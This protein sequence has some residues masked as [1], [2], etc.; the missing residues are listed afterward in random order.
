MSIEE[1]YEEVRELLVVGREQGYLLRDQ[2][3]EALPA[4]LGADEPKELM[5]ALA[6]G[7]IEVIDS[8]GAGASG[9]AAGP[10][11]ARL[12]AGAAELEPGHHVHDEAATAP[13][14]VRMYLRQIGTVRLLTRRGEVKIAQRM[15][16]AERRVMMSLSRSLTI[17]KHLVQVSQQLRSGERSVRELVTVPDG[18][19][20]EL[21]GARLAARTRQVV[22]R[23]DDIGAARLRLR[24]RLKRLAA[25]PKRTRRASRRAE[26]KTLRAWIALSRAVRTLAFTEAMTRELIHIVET[27]DDEVRR[28]QDRVARIE[29]QLSPAPTRAPARG[30][31][32]V[33]AG[34]HS[35]QAKRA[36]HQLVGELEETPE[37]LR[38]TRA[39]IVLGQARGAQAKRDLI[40]ANLR[41]VVSIAKK[42][43]NRGLA[44]LD[45]I[46]EGNIGLMRA[47]DKFDY[48]RGY[49]F[50]T[51]A[52]WWIRQAITRAIADHG[53]TIRIPV[54]MIDTINRVMRASQ[55]LVQ[56]LGREP[57][58]REIA[59]RTGVSIAKVQKVTKIA[60]QPIS[61][62]SPIGDDEDSR[63]GD[64]IEDRQANSPADA[65]FDLDLQQQTE[66]V[67]KTLTPRE[68]EVVR[69]RFGLRDG[70]E[71]TLAEVGESFALT[72]ER[73]RQIEAIALRKLRESSR[74]R[75]LRSFL[76][77]TPP[78]QASRRGETHP[79]GQRRSG[80]RSG[81]A[82]RARGSVQVSAEEQTT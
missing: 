56:E 21:T 61:L 58:V 5:A 36:L 34:A 7:G 22:K 47:V 39:A 52:T 29:G 71:P 54:H 67:L 75:K 80:P 14:P 6:S 65:V 15:E 12:S 73:I 18:D 82:V 41:L 30:A 37:R 74:N 45:L 2:I 64:F 44:F 81:R 27:A 77:W 70:S 72:R 62:E 3:S 76:E 68:Q 24:T 40:E 43:S 48:H 23:I 19:D 57:T 16:R 79:A 50:S 66:S 59:E 25:I 4:D 8:E 26:W 78:G 42:Y 60:Q 69:R 31:V 17:A 51:Y 32:H 46:Q 20:A 49:K 55:L 1:R 53:R 63:F 35:R 11:R 10:V 28:A 13:D 33:R 38:R 9:Q